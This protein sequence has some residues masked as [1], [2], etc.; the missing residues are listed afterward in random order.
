MNRFRVALQLYT[1]RSETAKDFLGACRAVKKIGYEFVELAG[2]GGFEAPALSY[3]LSEIG[4]RVSGSHVGLDAVTA[5]ATKTIEDHLAIGCKDVIVPWIP[6]ERRNSAKAWKETG[7]LLEEAAQKFREYG[8][9]VGFHNHAVEFQK[10]EGATGWDLLFGEA[11]SL[12]A[13]VDVFWVQYADADPVSVLAGVA[14]RVSS[15][16]AKDMAADKKD[17]EFGLGV[18][19]WKPVLAQCEKS[20]VETLVVEMDD[21]KIAPLESARVSYENLQRLLKGG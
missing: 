19:D 17:I 5:N 13:Q 16:H 11:P 10:F 9:R 18:I 2:F 15:I 4:L 8:L 14:N 1:I 21:P 20:G 12:W 6:D 3:H 7:N